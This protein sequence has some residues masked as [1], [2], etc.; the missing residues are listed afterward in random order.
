MKCLVYN[1]NVTVGPNRHWCIPREPGKIDVNPYSYMF[2]DC[3][4]V[5]TKIIQAALFE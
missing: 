3:K 1:S 4:K 2:G 5:K